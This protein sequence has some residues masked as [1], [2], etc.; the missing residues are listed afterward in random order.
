MYK[1][2]SLDF[3]SL[4]I[5]VFFIKVFHWEYWPFYILYFPLVFYWTWLSIKSRSIFFF[6]TSNPLIEYGGYAME[7][8]W[9]IY[10]L[11]PSKFF[12]STLFFKV[13]TP[14]E[15]IE[16]RLINQNLHFP[17][18]AKPD[19]GGKGVLV[20]KINNTH[21]L[22][23]YTQR[24]RVN[25][26][27][28]S[29]IEYP[30]EIGIFYYRMPN[31]KTGKIS[32]IVGKEFVSIKGDG[33]SSI[34]K[35]LLK[36][37]RYALQFE[38]I[39]KEMGDAI[40]KVLPLGEANILV[41]YGNHARGAKF[42][43]LSDKIN[44]DLTQTIHSICLQIPDFYF[45]RIDLMYHSWEELIRGEKFSIVELNGAGSEPTHIY[46]PK[47]SIFFAWKEISRHW[48]IL[49]IISR[50]NSL[51]KGIPYMRFGD[52]VKMLRDNLNYL[53]LIS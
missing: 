46:D 14:F 28:Q 24:I 41:P 17:L 51:N 29:F 39:Y 9:K 52:G 53:K 36:E 13:G 40:F 27:I 48:D 22:L 18:I 23:T 6:N 44:E 8:K 42:I 1:K 21:E 45:G 35:I 47:H 4:R 37:T 33:Y 50:Y 7:S 49:Q 30:N 2:S 20:K 5:R 16:A 25:Y 34:A 26:L 3:L 12:P 38:A 31:E 43:D 15:E 10:E 19:I 32:G 11:I